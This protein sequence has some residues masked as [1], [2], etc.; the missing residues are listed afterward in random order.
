MP[1]SEPHDNGFEL[2]IAR[3]CFAKRAQTL[4][5]IRKGLAR[6]SAARQLLASC[7]QFNACSI[8]RRCPD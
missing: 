1:V 3:P 8:R 5:E 2:T 4:G 7:T 6:I